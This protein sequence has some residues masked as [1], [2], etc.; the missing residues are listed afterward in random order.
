[1]APRTSRFA[2]PTKFV[3]GFILYA[4]AT[5]NA[6]AE[7][8]I[9]DVTDNLVA[10]TSN[11]TGTELTLFGAVEH[12][13]FDKDPE[14]VRPRRGDIVVVL[15]GP[16][17]PATVRRKERVAG[18]WANTDSLTFRKVPSFYFVAATNPLTEILSDTL[19]LR[20]EIGADYLRMEPEGYDPQV[21]HTAEQMVSMVHDLGEYRAAV[22]RNRQRDGLFNEII[23]G[24]QF[25]V[26][27][28]FRATLKIP[29]NVPVGNYTAEVYLVQDGAITDAQTSYIFI[30]K[31]GLERWIYNFANARPLPYGVAAVFI[32]LLAGWLA[33][34]I[35]RSD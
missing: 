7:R 5:G 18:V 11:F 14:T 31:I 23:G 34:M 13:P 27:N 17:E 3:F 9:A 21:G 12:S 29:S 2:L 6:Q 10:I 1:M 25:T 15:R 4:A 8:L 30:D 22:I 16:I 20:H 35:F 28:L 32:A 19:L 24:V 26:G 33:S